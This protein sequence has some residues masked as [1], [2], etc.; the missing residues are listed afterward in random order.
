[1]VTDISLKSEDF[2]EHTAKLCDKGHGHGSVKT[3]T[4]MAISPP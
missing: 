1:M 3:E 4:V 2:G